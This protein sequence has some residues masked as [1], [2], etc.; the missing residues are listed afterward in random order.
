MDTNLNEP[1]LDE[2]GAPRDILLKLPQSLS[3]CIA[4]NNF[5]RCSILKLCYSIL[6]SLRCQ[7]KPNPTPYITA[8]ASGAFTSPP[9]ELAGWR[10]TPRVC[11]L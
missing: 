7:G 8:C 11:E 4:H 2:R 1:L 5:L 10:C 3:S 6:T 9:P